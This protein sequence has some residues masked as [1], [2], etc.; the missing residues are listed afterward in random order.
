MHE[1][2]CTVHVH[3]LGGFITPAG[4][5]KLKLESSISYALAV[6]GFLL[7]VQDPCSVVPQQS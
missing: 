7:W 3:V 6:T 4:C 1:R 5:T 2:A